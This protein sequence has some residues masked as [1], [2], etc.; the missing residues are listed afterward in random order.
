[1]TVLYKEY[2]LHKSALVHTPATTKLV[3]DSWRSLTAANIV[4]NWNPRLEASLPT[5]SLCWLEYAGKQQSSRNAAADWTLGQVRK[6]ASLIFYLSLSYDSR[7]LK[8]AMSTSKPHSTHE[9]RLT[10]KKIGCLS[11]TSSAQDCVWLATKIALSLSPY[12]SPSNSVPC[13]YYLHVCWNHSG[14]LWNMYSEMNMGLIVT[15]IYNV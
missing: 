2:G 11:L 13:C 8:E 4:K 3:L 6:I 7:W 14:E 12:L 1:M 15:G 10:K 9:A 5:R